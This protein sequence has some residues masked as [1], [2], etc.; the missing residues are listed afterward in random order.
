MDKLSIMG[1]RI[2]NI[3]MNEVLKLAEQKIKNDEKYII[4]TPNTEIIMMCQKDEEFLNIFKQNLQ[5]AFSD[6]G[7]ELNVEEE[8]KKILNSE[9]DA[10]VK[11]IKLIPVT[12]CLLCFLTSFGPWGAFSVS[13]RSQM[14][15]LEKL[16]TAN[17]ILVDGKIKPMDKAAHKN[18]SDNDEGNISSIVHFLAERNSVSALQD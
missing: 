3:S 14:N 6:S 1:V 17:N 15:R 12:L 11:N 8:F 13:Q 2:N 10:K 5:S 16:L 18:I 9:D 7:E 4:Y